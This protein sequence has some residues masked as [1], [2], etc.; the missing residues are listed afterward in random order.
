MNL[1]EQYLKNVEI[2]IAMTSNDCGDKAK[3]GRYNRA[4]D[5]IR[6]TARMIEHKIP[7]LKS[8][9]FKLL[10]ND[11]RELRKWTAHLILEEMSCAK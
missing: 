4:S 3:V 5:K 2:L 7:G 8:E 1:I 6:R 11:N 10:S 9:F